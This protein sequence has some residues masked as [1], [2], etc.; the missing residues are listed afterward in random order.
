[1]DGLLTLDNNGLYCSQG[2][3]YIDPWKPVKQA[4]I[5]HAHADHLKPGSKK[6]FVTTKGR[7]ITEHR[8]KETEPYEMQ[9]FD[10]NETFQLNGVDISFHPAGHVLGSAQVRIE[11]NGEVWVNT[12]DY[13]RATDPTC[14]NFE[15]VKCDVFIT[16]ATF[17]VPIYRWD[18]G[19]I[20]ADQI[21]HWWS[22]NSDEGRPSVLFTYALGK[23]QR[24]LGELARLSDN[25]VYLHGALDAITTIYRNEGVKLLDT[26]LIPKK[27][28]EKFST[29]LILAPPSAYRSPWMKRF[30]NNSTAFASGWMR[31]RGRR[32]MQGYD[33]GFV[34]SDHA[35]WPNLVRTVKQTDASKIYITHG[36]GDVLA[37][38]LR[39]VEDIDATSVSTQFSNEGGEGE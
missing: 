11:H 19:E 27:S 3:F 5:T 16:E 8:L 4:I 28:K 7:R 33:K 24:V 23:A 2:D 6:Y 29:D 34:L 31:V 35:D 39:D 14:K 9:D 15:L 17:G 10:F 18:P 22:K 13:K 26:E 37:K 36:R 32:R 21:L 25:S 12:G 30:K 38:Y 20:I 1:M